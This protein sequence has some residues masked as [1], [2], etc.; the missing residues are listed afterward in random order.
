MCTC[1][2]HVLC[3]S[4]LGLKFTVAAAAAPVKPALLCERSWAGLQDEMS[5]GF[6]THIMLIPFCER[7]L[8]LCML[9]PV[10]YS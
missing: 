4:A 10:S 1:G 2:V 6:T 9:I 3:N 8:L 5:G 7:R